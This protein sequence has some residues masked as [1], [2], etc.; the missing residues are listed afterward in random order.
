MTRSLGA[1]L[2]AVAIVAVLVGV[3]LLTT[4]Y[5]PIVQGSSVGAVNGPSGGRFLRQDSL[6]AQEGGARWV[7]CAIPN[8]HFAWYVSL[9]NDGPLPVTIL[10]ADEPVS[11]ADAN[12][13]RLVDLAANDI[14]ADLATAPALAPTMIGPGEEIAVWARFEIGDLSGVTEDGAG[15]FHDQIGLR[16]S[17]L[18][19]S[20]SVD[21]MLRDEVGI[22]R[23]ECAS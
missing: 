5:M 17:I 10:G 4:T 18:G 8:G 6:E 11:P 14:N 19:I 3:G 9:R 7:Y 15:I 16:Y 2:V 22:E 1:G 23:G 12:G 20:R 21:V 13:F